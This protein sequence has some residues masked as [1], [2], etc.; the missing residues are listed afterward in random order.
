ML[1]FLECFSSSIKNHLKLQFLANSLS[2]NSDFILRW[3]LSILE[4]PSLTDY[5][6]FP[7]RPRQADPIAVVN[8]TLYQATHQHHPAPLNSHHPSPPSKR[9]LSLN[10]TSP[11]GLDPHPPTHSSPHPPDPTSHS[12]SMVDSHLHLRHHLPFP[13]VHY[14]DTTFAH[15]PPPNRQPT[16]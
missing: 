5:S 16:P 11:Q 8:H 14:H 4:I 15:R 2:S 3:S 6:Y 9:K 7:D 10:S 1:V 13:P 12:P